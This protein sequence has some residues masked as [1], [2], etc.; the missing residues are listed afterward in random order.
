MLVLNITKE[1]FEEEVLN[2]DIPVLIDFWAP[3]CAPCR[4]LAPVIEELANEVTTAKVAK[5]NI[6]EEPELA[7][8]F[9]VMSI[10]TI[11]VVKDRKVVN[12]VVGVRDKS[13]LLEML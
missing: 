13:D 3:W 1:N 8:A 5:I 9:S 7:S 4:M 12:S 2:S 10:P 6:D 11:V